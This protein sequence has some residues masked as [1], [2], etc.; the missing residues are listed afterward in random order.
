MLEYD[1]RKKFDRTE[2]YRVF[3]YYPKY[4]EMEGLMIDGYVQFDDLYETYL[5]KKEE[6]DE[7]CGLSLDINFDNPTYRDLLNLTDSLTAYGLID[8]FYTN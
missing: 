7:F 3:A 2:D 5:E 8:H 1:G 4:T 6:V